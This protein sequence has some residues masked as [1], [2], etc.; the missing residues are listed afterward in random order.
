[1]ANNRVRMV[2][3]QEIRE[4]SPTV[5]TF[6]FHDKR[7][8]K[9]RPGQFVMVWIP[10]VDEIPISLSA[11]H[12]NG[13]SEITVARVGE[14][15]EALHQRGVGDLIGVRGP[16][17]NG[18]TLVDGNIL[19]V[20][21]GIGLA[22]LMPLIESLTKKPNK[23]IGLFGAK[24]RSELLFL[25][26]IEK[27]FLRVDG[28]LFVTTEDGSYGLKGLATDLLKEIL[29]SEQFDMVYTCGP[30]MM[31]HKVFML[32]E[33]YGTPL[34]ASLE[35]IMHCAI[36]LCGGCTI[37]EF[38]VCRDGPIFTSDQLRKVIDEFGRFKRGFDGR[39]ILFIGG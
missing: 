20:G 16:Y 18:F 4:E 8:G 5:K 6:T 30:E 24:T 34:Q 17:G 32:T 1:M 3:I 10:K 27:S 2:R 19:I 12:P 14:A 36:G 31:M 9:A 7:C 22:P 39:R 21:G 38:R 33:Q 11:I 37:G 13:R 26:R 28:K 29:S 23:I 25:N 35:R 15:T